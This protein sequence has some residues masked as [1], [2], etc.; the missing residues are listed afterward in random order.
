MN[1]ESRIVVCTFESSLAKTRPSIAVISVP[2][3]ADDDF[4]S[5]HATHVAAARGSAEG[6][7]PSTTPDFRPSSVSAQSS[8]PDSR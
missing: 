4:L 7:W 6:S 1:A 2:G 8:E 5:G 3:V